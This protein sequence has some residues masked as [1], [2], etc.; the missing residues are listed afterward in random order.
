LKEKGYAERYKEKY[1]EIYL[2]EIE[3]NKEK[4]EITRFE[5]ERVVKLPQRLIFCE[6]LPSRKQKQWTCPRTNGPR[7]SEGK[8]YFLEKMSKFKT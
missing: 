5:W 1:S 4:R 6:S 8:L 7:M 3:F 2:V